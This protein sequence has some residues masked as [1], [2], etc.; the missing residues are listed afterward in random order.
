MNDAETKLEQ[1]TSA[2]DG[3]AVLLLVPLAVVAWMDRQPVLEELTAI[4][5]HHARERCSEELGCLSEEARQ[6][7]YHHFVYVKPSAR[8]VAKALD[9][10]IRR[11]SALPIDEANHV[12]HLLAN[13]CKDVARSAGGWLFGKVSAGEHKAVRRLIKF[14]QSRDSSQAGDLAVKLGFELDPHPQGGSA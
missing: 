14:V 1:I 7:F 5:S 12:T 6:F 2:Q 3:Q 10:L 4:A 13:A 11:L 8:L 9:L